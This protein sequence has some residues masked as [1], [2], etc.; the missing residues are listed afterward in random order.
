MARK[1]LEVFSRELDPQQRKLLTDHH[2]KFL[3]LPLAIFRDFTN[4][5]SIITDE[6]KKKNGKNPP[7]FV[8]N[9]LIEKRHQDMWQ[10]DKWNE[11]NLHKLD[12]NW[13]NSKRV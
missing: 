8:V 6:Q 12:Y 11:W 2:R 1:P 5:R 10:L 13:P 9:K 7:G 3:H 4:I